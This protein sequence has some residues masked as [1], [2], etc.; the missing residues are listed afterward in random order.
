MRRLLPLFLL[1]AMGCMAGSPPAQPGREGWPCPDDNNCI[2]PLACVEGFCGEGVRDAG[3]L[4][5]DAGLIADAGDP[6]DVGGPVDTGVEDAGDPPDTGIPVCDIPYQLSAV[7]TR[8]FGTEGN[9]PCS[10]ATCHGAGSAGG[11]RLSKPP[12]ELR[13]DLLGP[14]RDPLAPQRVLVDPGNPEGSRL[15][16]IMSRLN[17]GGSRG[18]MPPAPTPLLGTCELE[19]VAGWIT[20]GALAN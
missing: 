2:A 13:A 8:V 6:P 5:V 18:P 9:G 16:V 10:Q 11:I 1:T 4:P 3:V 12:A 14:T 15:Y 20:D 7:Q 17:P 19:A